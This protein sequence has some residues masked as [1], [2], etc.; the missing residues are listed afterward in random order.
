MRKLIIICLLFLFSSQLSFSQTTKVFYHDMF[1]SG[2]PR[3]GGEIWAYKLFSFFEPSE[4]MIEYD[5]I[6]LFQIKSNKLD[7]Q[8]KK[9]KNQ[10]TKKGF[11]VGTTDSE[12]RDGHWYNYAFI[13]TDNDTLYSLH[14]FNRW[15]YK[16]MAL[17]FH[18]TS[19]DLHLPGIIVY[20]EADETDE[21]ICVENLKTNQIKEIASQDQIRQILNATHSGEQTSRSFKQDYRI[22]IYCDVYAADFFFDIS[23]YKKDV[24][25]QKWGETYKMEKKWSRKIRKYLK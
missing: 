9:I 24:L 11:V 5:E 12:I 22:T 20:D 21:K 15:R 10:I 16:N 17:D 1:S 6:K 13:T 7:A 18:I 8:L 4:K 14:L 3:G 2:M 19:L 23:T 25:Y